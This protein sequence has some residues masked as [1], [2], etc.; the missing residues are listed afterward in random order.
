MTS[1]KENNQ[2]KKTIEK[3]GHANDALENFKKNYMIIYVIANETKKSYAF[4]EL[5]EVFLT[6]LVQLRNVELL[7]QRIVEFLN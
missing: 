2:L 1:W 5:Q 3:K 4:H 7:V 6:A